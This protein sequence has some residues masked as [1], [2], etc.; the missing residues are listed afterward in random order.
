MYTCLC[1]RRLFQIYLCVSVSEKGK[2]IMSFVVH[3]L[4]NDNCLHFV[5]Q[6]SN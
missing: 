1:I 2:E 3:N 6:G 4:F 5:P